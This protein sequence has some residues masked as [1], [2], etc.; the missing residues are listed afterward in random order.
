MT[1]IALLSKSYDMSHLVASIAQAAP[2]L[3]VVM[4]DE[5]GAVD[6]EIAACW[7]PPHGRMAEMPRLKLIHGIAAGVDNILSDASLPSLPLCRVVDPQHG[8]GMSEFVTWAVLHLFR[9]M[10]RVLQNQRQAIWHRFDQPHPSHCQI[11]VM[12][13]GEIGGRVATDLCKQGFSVKGWSRRRRSLPNIESFAGPTEMASFL[14][15]TDILICLLP[16]TDETLGILSKTTF[17]AMKP[18]AKLI[19]VGRGEHLNTDDLHTALASGQLGGAI[20][21]VFPNEPLPSDDA[22]WHCTNLTITPHMAS[23][24]SS[25]TIGLQIAQ[26]VRRFLKNEPLL[27]VVDVTRGY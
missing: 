6:A 19:H 15:N 8:R 4:A 10:D 3:K 14:T 27:N 1:T 5:P 11:G 23:M 22:L 26:N 9:R 16:L 17:S 7:D 25:E 13:L 21:D 20:V 2:E 12:G 18:G 24:A